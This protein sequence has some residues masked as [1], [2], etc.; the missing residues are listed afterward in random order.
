[1]DAVPQEIGSAYVALTTKGIE[2]AIKDLNTVKVA[3]SDATKGQD[4]LNDRLKLTGNLASLADVQFRNLFGSVGKLAGIKLPDK[5]VTVKADGFD[6]IEAG[7]AKL[8]TTVKTEEPKPVAVKV[9]QPDPIKPEVL[10]PDPVAVK[11]QKP[12][13]IKPEILQPAPVVVSI[14]ENGIKEIASALAA[15]KAPGVTVQAREEGIAKIQ[16]AIDELRPHA[17][18][19]PVLVSGLDQIQQGINDLKAPVVLPVKAD[20][21][22]AQKDVE[23][24]KVPSLGIPVALQGIRAAMGQI[25]NVKSALA[26]ALATTTDSPAFQKIK[27]GTSAAIEG[28]SKVKAAVVGAL[29][30]ATDIAKPIKYSGASILGTLPAIGMAE[31][32]KQA[33]NYLARRKARQEKGEVPTLLDKGVNLAASRQEKGEAPTLLDKGVNLAASATKAVGTGAVSAIG[34]L[35]NKAKGVNLAPILSGM[36]AVGSGAVAAFG[37][38]ASSVGAFLGKLN[39]ETLAQFGSK[40]KE[41]GAAV[42][43]SISQV[44]GVAARAFAGLSGSIAATVRLADP[45]GWLNFTTAIQSVTIQIGRIFIPLLH[46]VTGYLAQLDRFLRNMTDAQREQILTWVKTAVVVSGAVLAFTQLFGIVSSGFTVMSGFVGILT[47]LGVSGPVGWVIALTAALVGLA[48]VVASTSGGFSGIFAGLRPALAGLLS[49]FQSAFN[50]LKE[51]IALVMNFIAGGIG[52]AIQT[53]TPFILGVASLIANTVGQLSSIVTPLLNTIFGSATS[54]FSRVSAAIQTTLGA[55]LG[56]LQ[57]WIGN[58]VKLWQAVAPELG[59]I[60]KTLFDIWG[61]YATSVQGNL[62][63]LMTPL[64]TFIGLVYDV[65]VPIAK[66]AFTAVRMYLEAWKPILKS[67]FDIGQTIWKAISDIL[68]SLMQAVKPLF[69]AFGAG[70]GVV[71]VFTGLMQILLLPLR[72]LAAVLSFL[73]PII[74]F[75][76]DGLVLAVSVAAAVLKPQIDLLVMGFRLGVDAVKAFVAATMASVEVLRTIGRNPGALS[77]PEVLA[78]TFRL[79][80]QRQIQVVMA[81]NATG[82]ANPAASGAQPQQPQQPSNRFQGQVLQKSELTSIASAWARAQTGDPNDPQLRVLNLTLN[83]A[84]RHNTLLETIVEMERNRNQGVAGFA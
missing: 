59:G 55:V 27:A 17:V 75:F 45:L 39:G 77:R 36:K 78:Q 52:T 8:K 68:E 5:E 84:E 33:T 41:V 9:Q 61:D 30:K 81:G 51:P 66:V 3:L 32:H 58:V 40:I 4:A 74:K 6:A 7:L 65:V 38:A 62:A 13:P 49:A 57:T 43:N 73:V 31:T 80:Y 63:S 48:A 22:Q 25:A 42:N 2:Q 35:V 16:A 67:L 11:V 71:S 70:N 18:N 50:S 76:A 20:T 72:G 12:D 56:V 64:K 79:E 24:V 15:L 37:S 44:G 26:S 53:V 19:V 69:D 23:A 83:Q 10:Q 54:N 29:D 82:A 46:Q 47:A 21:K 14:V 1:M 28:F 60:F 34:A